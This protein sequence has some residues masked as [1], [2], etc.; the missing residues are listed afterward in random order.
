MEYKKQELRGWGLSWQFETIENFVISKPTWKKSFWENFFLSMTPSLTPTNITR[1]NILGVLDIN[2]IE[3]VVSNDSWSDLNVSVWGTIV[4]TWVKGESEK[5]LSLRWGYNQTLSWTIIGVWEEDPTKDWNDVFEFWYIKL[6]LDVTPNVGDYITFTSNTT[7]LQG[8]STQIHYIQW[9]F[10]YVRWTNLY[11]TLPTVGEN[12]VIHTHIWDTLVIAETD[13][14]ISVD[15]SWNTITLYT[16]ND[17][18]AIIDIE[19][20]NWT[21]FILTNNYVLYWRS[22]V[23]C[24]M[25]VYPLD[26]F[27]NMGW[28]TRILSFGKHL[29]LFWKNNQ[30]ISPVNGTEWSLWYVS[31]DLNYNHQLFSKYS[32]ISIQWSLYLLQDDKEFVKVDIVAVANWEYDLVTGDA[33]PEAKGMLEDIS[34]EVYITKWDKYISIINDNWGWTSTVYSY[35]LSYQHWVTW[36]FWN[37]LRSMWDKI[38]WETQFTRGTDIIDQEIS[39]QLGGESLSNMKTCYFVKMTLVAETDVVP[40]YTFTIDKYIWGM[41]YTKDIALKDYPINNKILRPGNTLGYEQFGD[42]QLSTPIYNDELWYI[43]NVQVKVNE[44]ADMFIF[45]LKNN[46]NRITYW[47]WVIWY[48]NWLPEVTAYNYIIK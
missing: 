25:N 5:W 35:N 26:F 11:W 44:T 48:K 23:N 38:Y 40:D 13:K 42:T 8:I 43:I 45:T 27:D 14:V 1:T 47:G 21:L 3:T 4:Y 24:N 28:W 12:I 39:F 20:F 32:A 2:S 19:Y 36:I 33:M 29:I 6:E 31:N 30:I 17:D 34:W 18:D 7:N 10:C 46:N 37:Q 16:C 41:K 9:G 15:T 22:L